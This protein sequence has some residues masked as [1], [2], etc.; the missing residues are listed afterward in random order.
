MNNSPKTCPCRLGEAVLTSIHN[1][2]FG[3]KIRSIGIPVPILVYIKV[4]FTGECI[5][6]TCFPDENKIYLFYQLSD[7][8]K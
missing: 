7:Y 8:I 2:C 5:S 6:R 1:L 3:A 4:G